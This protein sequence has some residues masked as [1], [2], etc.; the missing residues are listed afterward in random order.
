MCVACGPGFPL[1]VLAFPVHNPYTRCGL[2]TAIPNAP[3]HN[4]VGNNMVGFKNL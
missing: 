2:Y 3:P 4:P 1:Q